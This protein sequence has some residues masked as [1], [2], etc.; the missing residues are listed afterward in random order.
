MVLR[1]CLTWGGV[2]PLIA[3]LLLAGPVPASGQD[4]APDAG[5]SFY[6]RE[7]A[8]CHGNAATG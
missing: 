6:L 1:R 2:V 7:C 5:R 3:P 4:H 8:P